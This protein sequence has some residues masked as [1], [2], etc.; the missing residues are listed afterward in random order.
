MKNAISIFTVLAFA[1]LTNAY[2]QKPSIEL[3]FDAAYYG[4]SM[5]LDSIYIENLTQ[6]GDTMLFYPD[7]ILML[8]YTEGEIENHSSAEK[9]FVLSQNFPNPFMEK[10]TFSIYLPEDDFLQVSVF[11]ALG[12]QVAT[13]E[14]KLNRGHHSFIFYPG[15]E[16]NY[17]LTAK[18][19]G[20]TRSIKMVNVNNHPG[21]DCKLVYS[22]TNNFDNPLVKSQ[23][24]GPRCLQFYKNILLQIRPIYKVQLNPISTKAI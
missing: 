23:I 7:N 14:N 3:T 1:I 8:N 16:R 4:Q 22:T 21:G 6:G 19:K 24:E 15:K 13:F 17:F 2:C 9:A 12:K 11:N 5:Q 10:T 20:V 18:V